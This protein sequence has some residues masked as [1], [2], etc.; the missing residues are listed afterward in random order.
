MVYTHALNCG[1]RESIVLLIDFDGAVPCR[2]RTPT[3]WQ[4]DKM[5]GWVVD[6]RKQDIQPRR[7]RPREPAKA[8][9]GTVLGLWNEEERMAERI[10]R[11]IV[12][13]VQ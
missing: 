6:R 7:R 5:D 4:S 9:L 10:S 2:S 3:I 11:Q 13:Q 12:R 8:G 1:K